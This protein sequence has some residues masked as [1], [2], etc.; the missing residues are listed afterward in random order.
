MGK[1]IKIVTCR[2]QFLF[3]KVYVLWRAV[4]GGEEQP[5]RRG[6]EPA[7]A[8][9]CSLLHSPTS[10]REHKSFFFD[11]SFLRLIPLFLQFLFFIAFLALQF[12]P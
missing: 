8:S 7:G 11:E 2:R 3:Q 6:C 5:S 12:S 1:Y 10:R 9:V 4:E